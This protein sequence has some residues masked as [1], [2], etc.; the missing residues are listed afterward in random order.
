MGLIDRSL[1][2]ILAG[3]TLAL[4]VKKF[5]VDVNQFP[6][7][8]IR[9]FVGTLRLFAL[10]TVGDAESPGENTNSRE[11]RMALQERCHQD[12]LQPHNM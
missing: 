7:G 11:K 4:V 3:G 2:L 12:T 1:L 9:A 10:C 6:R 5:L 8:F